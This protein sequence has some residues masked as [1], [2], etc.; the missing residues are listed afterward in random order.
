MEGTTGGVWGASFADFAGYR[1]VGGWRG[2]LEGSGWT[3]WQNLPGIGGRGGGGGG[4]EEGGRGGGGG[5]RRA[6]ER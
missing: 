5:R 6:G 4:E 2:R 1:E 3:L